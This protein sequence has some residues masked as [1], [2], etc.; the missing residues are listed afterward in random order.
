MVI[1]VS[2]VPCLQQDSVC[3]AASR[4]TKIRKEKKKK[5][6]REVFFFSWQVSPQRVFFFVSLSSLVNY[7]N[8]RLAAAA[9]LPREL[10][11]FLKCS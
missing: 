5:V 8:R 11:Y 1:S 2:G 10:A 4:P 6:G 7:R 9:L 3:A